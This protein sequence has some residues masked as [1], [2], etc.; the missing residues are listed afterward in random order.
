[1]E[2]KLNRKLRKIAKKA[3]FIFWSDELYGPGKNYID[4]GSVYD[5]E[6]VNFA[7]LLIEKCAK[8]ADD[9]KDIREHFGMQKG[10]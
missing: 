7:N 5:A 1:M 9:G 10:D 6:M 3:G 4:W 2:L 8:L